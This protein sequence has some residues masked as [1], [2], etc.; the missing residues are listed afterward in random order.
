VSASEPH[1][2]TAIVVYATA[3]CPYCLRARLLLD[4]L[5]QSYQLIDVGRDRQAR[6]EMI[7]RAGGRSSVPQIFIGARHVGGYDD[8]ARAERDGSLDDWL[9]EAG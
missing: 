4:G 9:A 2:D 3:I 5:G 8:L 7:Q 6:G 1:T